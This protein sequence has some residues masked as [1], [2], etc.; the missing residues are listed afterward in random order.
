VSPAG[1]QT[2]DDAAPPVGRHDGLLTRSLARVEMEVGEE[3]NE[4]GFAGKSA[5]RW[6]CSRRESHVTVHR[7]WTTH[8]VL[9]RMRPRQVMKFAAQA[10]AAFW[11]FRAGWFG[12]SS[13]LWAGYG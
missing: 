4:L 12:P 10:F 9:V 8:S 2:C 13:V 6:F 11:N 3:T 5:A 7:R 1:E